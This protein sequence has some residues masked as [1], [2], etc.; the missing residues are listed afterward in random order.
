MDDAAHF[1]FRISNF[2]L[3]VGRGMGHIEIITIG[4][5]LVEGRLVDTNAGLMSARLTDEGLGVARHTS[6][7]DDLEVI[8]EVLRTA[9]ARSDAVLVSGG[10]GPTS[11]DL[12]AEAAAA[13]FGLE[14]VCNPA[15]LE[16]VRNFFADRGRRMSLNN[17][18]QADLPA[19]C[20][21]L[22]NPDGTA[23][24][25][26]LRIGDCRLYFMPGVPRELDHIFSETVLP[27]LRSFLSGSPPTVV[28]LKVFGKGESDVAQML[29]GLEN[30]VPDGARLTI[31]YRATFPEIHIRLLLQADD[32]FDGDSILEA[33]ERD[34]AER[35]G[36]YLFAIGGAHVETSFPQQVMNEARGAGISLSLAEGCTGG[37]LARLVTGAA[38]GDEVF[39]GGMVAPKPSALPALLGVQS[40][41]TGEFGGI[42]EP[43]AAA[44][45]DMVRAR[46]DADVGLAVTGAPRGGGSAAGTLIVAISTAGGT[47]HRRFDFPLEPDRFR[48]LAA[49]VALAMLRQTLMGAA[50]S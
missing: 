2:E 39:V 11:D 3:A 28:T 1:E 34:A 10:L 6:V 20:T 23:T 43:T 44:A 50:K 27:D 22:P 8:A 7:S 35:L 15:A 21:L 36:K 4:D 13:A 30:G 14:V 5:E 25:F 33:L 45:A 9:A 12:T 19:G 26:G 49:Y 18:K 46:F 48:R 47:T 17:E 42:D 31:Q 16:H 32:D 37:E 24:G 41:A 40:D 38:C 29:T